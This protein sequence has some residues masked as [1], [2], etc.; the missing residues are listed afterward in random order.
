MLPCLAPWR[1]PYW[2]WDMARCRTY[3]WT[4]SPS[5]SAR[6]GWPAFLYLKLQQI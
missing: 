1:P 2:S 5:I 4:H 3:G 6:L